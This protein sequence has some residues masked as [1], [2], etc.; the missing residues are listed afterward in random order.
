MKTN[1]KTIFT[2]LFFF[3]CSKGFAQTPVYSSYPSAAATIFLDFDGHVVEGTSWNMSGPINCAPANMTPQQI[4]EIYHRVA[5]DYRPFNVNVTTDSAK[6]EAAPLM[7]RIRIICTITSQWYGSA[8]GV[9][10]YNS[11]TWGDNTPAF[12]FTELLNYKAKNVAEAASHEAGHSLGL[13]H[14]SAYDGNCAKTAE[15]NAG[16]GVG[17]IGWAPIMGVG[18]YRNQTLWNNG[19]DPYGCNSF[20]NDLQVITTYN[21]FTYRTDDYSSSFGGS[22]SQ[23]FFTNSAFKVDGVIEKSADEDVIKFMMPVYGRF[24]LHA[25]PSNTGVGN[26]GANLDVQIELMENSHS[27]IG[28]YNP[29]EALASHV[30][31]ML[32]PG[33][34]FLRI[35]GKGNVNAPQYATL[36]SYSLEGSYDVPI[37][38]PLRKLELQGTNVNGRH[39]FNWIIDADEKVVTQTLEVSTDGRNYSAVTGLLPAVRNYLYVPVASANLYYRLNVLFDNGRSSYSNVTM[40][41]SNSTGKPQLNN[42][43][44]RQQLV[45]SSLAV[46]NY[47]VSDNNG[48]VFS[49]GTVTPGA[50]TIACANWNAG[51]YIIQ[52][53]NGNEHYTEKFMKQ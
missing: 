12:V 19:N 20:Q 30:D 52:F 44:V 16:V 45:V 33:S 21:G 22:G 50:N 27:V 7:Q 25:T 14:Q 42:T 48:R 40:L 26:S 9:S 35:Q 51:M 47:Q 8:G 32:K 46:F 15:Y 18:Y 24:Q 49:A 23:V 38:L 2:L 53:S 3:A 13:R 4:T 6:Y 39:N 43:V 11:F 5:E 28:L 17:E 41:R 34:Y 36:G 10:F 29:N 31:T 37:V 1:F